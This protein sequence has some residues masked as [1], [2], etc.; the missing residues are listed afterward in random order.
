MLFRSVKSA[1]S[2]GADGVIVEVHNNPPMALCDGAQ[3]LTPSEFD[4][5]MKDVKRRVEFEG[6]KL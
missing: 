5:L 3:S 1:I 6:K 4:E 2:I